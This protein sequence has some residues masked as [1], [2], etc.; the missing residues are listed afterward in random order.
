MY[1]YSRSQL[2][3]GLNFATRVMASNGATNGDAEGLAFV[4]RRTR[5]TYL[6]IS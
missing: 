1:A 3:Q 5:D 6:I 4:A 2:G